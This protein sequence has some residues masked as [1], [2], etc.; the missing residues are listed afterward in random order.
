MPT[1]IAEDN[2]LH[3]IFVSVIIMYCI[4]PCCTGCLSLVFYVFFLIAVLFFV[5]LVY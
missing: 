4:F 2:I 5:L 1:S 3:K